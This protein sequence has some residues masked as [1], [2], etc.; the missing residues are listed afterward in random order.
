MQQVM[1]S[2]P[3]TS[4]SNHCNNGQVTIGVGAGHGGG[5]CWECAAR[6]VS[7]HQC[8]N[9]LVL[10]NVVITT[11]S[12]NILHQPFANTGRRRNPVA[13][14]EHTCLYVE[15]LPKTKNALTR[16]ELKHAFHSTN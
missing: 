8:V 6:G 14:I 9:S 15:S 16:A 4:N 1:H 13:W 7:P 12:N 11:A 3:N 2:P 5:Q 10:Q